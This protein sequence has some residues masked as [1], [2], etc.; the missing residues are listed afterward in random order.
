MENLN[1]LYEEINTKLTKFNEDHQ[2]AMAGNKA[3]ARR[4]RVISVQIRKALKDYRELS[5]KA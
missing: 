3:A 5:P 4:C 1:N 2:L